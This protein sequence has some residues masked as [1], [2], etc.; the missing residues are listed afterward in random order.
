MTARPRTRAAIYTRISSDP[1]GDQLGVTRQ[2][3]DCR[4]LCERRG[5]EVAGV[6]TDD[7]RSAYSGKPRPRY[8]ELCNDIKAGKVD[9]VVAWHPDR[10][11]RS[12]RELEDWIDLID[13][14]QVRVQTVT[15]GEQDFSTA[16]GRMYARITGSIARRESE[17]KS[18]RIR[19]K[20]VELAAA[21]KPHGGSRPYGYG[22]D[23]VTVDEA[24]AEVV[25]EMVRRVL[26][27]ESLRSIANDLNERGVRTVTGKT[28]A[29]ATIRGMVMSPRIAGFREH[30][31]AVNGKRVRSGEVAGKA[32][33]TA[34]VDEESWR[35]VRAL[36]TD[37]ARRKNR[38]AQ[39][40]LL[41]GVIFCGR[42][43]APL[44]AGGRHGTRHYVC[45]NEPGRRPGCGRL[46]VVAERVEEVV[47]ATVLEAASERDLAPSAAASSPDGAAA[48]EARMVELAEDWS[49]G[50]LSR[51]EWHAARRSLEAQLGEV[52][53]AEAEGLRTRARAAALADLPS[54]WPGMTF[55]ERRS[56]LLAALKHV[57]IAPAN[58]ANRFDPARVSIT[59]WRG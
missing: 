8:I 25:R 23:K 15:A 49:R 48:I 11:H 18:Q 21:G 34:I 42:C 53:Q 6:Y 27:G 52:E 47:V 56:V 54:R 7:D 50:E 58:G 2:E 17:H 3:E 24:E 55:D 37:P 46:K 45:N 51:P 12:P 35:R 43:D 57:V 20:M 29:T 31:P 26:A 1:D 14:A 10:V 32:M 4:T 30:S 36:L 39:R 33:W 38:A 19:R 44:V 28:W 59:E 13:A 22:K 41:T 9:A 40:Y 5:W 16:D